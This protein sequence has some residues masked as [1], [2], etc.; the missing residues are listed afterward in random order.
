MPTL[1]CFDILPLLLLLCF[2]VSVYTSDQT[3][4][5]KPLRPLWS[6]KAWHDILSD[7]PLKAA[8]KRSGLLRPDGWFDVKSVSD[9]HYIDGMSL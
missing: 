7:R 9:M 4:Y 2:A 1:H 5:S 6:S 8:I 3:Q